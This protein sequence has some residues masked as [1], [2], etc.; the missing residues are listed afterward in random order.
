WFSNSIKQPNPALEQ[1]Q[2]VLELQCSCCL[3]PFTEPV[4]ITGCGHSFCQGCILSYCSSRPRALCPL[5]RRPFEPRHL[6]PNRELAAL[7]S[8][9]PRELQ[10]RWDPQ[11]EPEPCGA[12]ACN[13]LSVAERAPAEKVRPGAAG[14]PSPTPAS[15][16][17]DISGLLRDSP[18]CPGTPP[19]D[20]PQLS[21]NIPG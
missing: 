2:R 16:S 10:D 13:D 17:P 21:R 15:F 12:A 18:N 19:G 7:L 14:A 11:Q 5:C 8:L 4:R 9:I 20:I 6:R 3:Q 1:L